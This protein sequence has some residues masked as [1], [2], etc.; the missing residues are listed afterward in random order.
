MLFTGGALFDDREDAGRKLATL[1]DVPAGKAVVL[2]IARGGIPV[3]YPIAV[4]LDAPLDVVTARK[5]PIPWSPEMGFGAIAPDGSLVLNDQLVARL[6]L[7]RDEINSIAEQVLAE[8]RRREGAYRGGRPAVAIEGKN[9]ILTDDG[10]ATGYTM[11]A[12]VEMAKKRMA[13]SITV[14]VPVSPEDTARRIEPMVDHL[15]CM[16][17][18]RTYSFAVAS[19][20]RDFHDMT[21]RE[22]LDYLEKAAGPHPS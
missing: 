16:H 9:V 12:A 20:Y 2:G 14:A 22:V 7:S 21:D 5:L 8:V 3:G 13:A 4:K 15:V 18:A 17:I 10:L 6:V 1:I 11:I 19:F